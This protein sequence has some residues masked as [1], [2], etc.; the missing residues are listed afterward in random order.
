MKQILIER[1]LW[2][3]GLIGH[4]QLCKLKIEDLTRTDCCIYRILSLKEDFKSQ[5]LQLQEEIEKR[6]HLCIFYLKFYCELN[7]IKMYWKAAKRYTR[8]NCDYI[9]LGLQKIVPEALDSI[10]LITIRKFARK[11]WRYIV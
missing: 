6:E 8:E 1:N 9:W 3:N 2:Y 10:P 11:S 4:C 7:F 5:K